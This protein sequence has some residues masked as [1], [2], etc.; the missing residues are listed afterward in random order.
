MNNLITQYILEAAGSSDTKQV[1]DMLSNM[2]VRSVLMELA[3]K[4]EEFY[5]KH[6]DYLSTPV[7]SSLYIPISSKKTKKV[8]KKKAKFSKDFEPLATLSYSLLPLFLNKLYGVG[9]NESKAKK[10]V[11]KEKI[12]PLILEIEKIFK[13]YYNKKSDYTNAKKAL[14]FL[15]RCTDLKSFVN[16]TPYIT[17]IYNGLFTKKGKDYYNNLKGK[18][19]RLFNSFKNLFNPYK[20]KVKSSLFVPIQ[21][22]K[23]EKSF[24]ES[25]EIY[26]ENILDLRKL[27][28]DLKLRDYVESIKREDILFPKKAFLVQRDDLDQITED[29]FGTT[30]PTYK[31]V[32]KFAKEDKDEFL[33]WAKELERVKKIGNRA[34]KEEWEA[35]GYKPDAILS[36]D[37]VRTFLKKIKLQDKNLKIFGTLNHFIDPGFKG[38]VSLG[39]NSTVFD[40]YTHDN[41][42]LGNA[43]TRKVIMNP[44]Y[45]KKEGD[46][47]EAYYCKSLANGYYPTTIV[48]GKNKGKYKPE[49]KLIKQGKNK[50]QWRAVSHTFTKTHD[51]EKSGNKAELVK[52][53]GLVIND[54]RN[55]LDKDIK[56]KGKSDKKTYATIGR[57]SDLTYIRMGN[58][59]SAKKE[60]RH[61]LTT[62]QV[63][64]FQF[65]PKKKVMHI[66]YI[67]K[68][69]VKHHKS[70]TDPTIIK[71]ILELSKGKD[72]DDFIFTPAKGRGKNPVK[73]DD[74][75]DYLKSLKGWPG[76]A[77]QKAFR[78]FHACR[79]FNEAVAKF[80]D[81]YN[82]QK[83]KYS[84][85]DLGKIF[86]EIVKGV[87]KELG[88]TPG[89]CKGSY[90]D[91]A[92]ML[93]FFENYD[94]PLNK[95]MIKI[96]D[97]SYLSDKLKEEE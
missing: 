93:N 41:K 68:S 82:K 74:V 6:G 96:I 73:S 34:I 72:K 46:R 79:L 18:E 13:K 55:Q 1:D 14:D 20:E 89:A 85:T 3:G 77:T 52:Q 90:I 16:R 9:F 8:T 70:L 63:K 43:P 60:D 17:F 67:G 27:L 49:F 32:V 50:G 95:G 28:T 29:T 69:H 62:M 57:M 38:N 47:K 61:G 91:P 78:T 59:N 37:K 81:K 30:T 76:D 36:A 25:K 44:E 24:P 75:N 84:K 26:L 10:F 71:Y 39:P 45:K 92:L 22:A 97:N 94:I 7:S 31:E 12:K 80:M 2:S 65:D 88:H 35:E 21:G 40:Y 48:K 23:K 54:I 42:P 83:K 51:Q 56:K 53:M 58:V 66:R 64:N 87:A 5:E 19:K 86:K 33:D 4:K 15:K 11:K